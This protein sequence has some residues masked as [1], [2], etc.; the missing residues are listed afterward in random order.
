MVPI[1]VTSII[2]QSERWADFLT[3]RLQYQQSNGF[4]SSSQVTIIVD[5][6]LTGVNDSAGGNPCLFG[7]LSLFQLGQGVCHNFQ[8]PI[9][10][11]SDFMNI[12]DINSYVSLNC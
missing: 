4:H 11:S 6:Q 1:N 8:E 10:K 12:N 3:Y 9:Q 5:E 2:S 7:S